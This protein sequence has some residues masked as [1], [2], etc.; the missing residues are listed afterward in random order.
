MS[1]KNIGAALTVIAASAAVATAYATT[2]T[3]LENDKHTNSLITEENKEVDSS[4]SFVKSNY[5]KEVKNTK[6][7]GSKRNSK[8]ASQEIKKDIIIEKTAKTLVKPQI[9]KA[10]EVVAYNKQDLDGV[11]KYDSKNLDES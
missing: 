6:I 11:V 3:D 7:A 1:K 9:E 8:K 2:V 10:Q 4:Y 5:T